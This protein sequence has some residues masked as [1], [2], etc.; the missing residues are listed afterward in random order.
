MKV[1]KEFQKRQDKKE[2]EKELRGLARPKP[3]SKPKVF[4]ARK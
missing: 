3:Y 1:A 2:D 4:V